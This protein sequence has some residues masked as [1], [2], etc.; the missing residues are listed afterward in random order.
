MLAFVAE[1]CFQIARSESFQ[2]QLLLFKV[3]QDDFA[4]IIGISAIGFGRK[5]HHTFASG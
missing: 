3:W 4:H 2:G 5:A 1:K